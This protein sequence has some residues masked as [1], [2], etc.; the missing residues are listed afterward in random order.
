MLLMAAAMQ[1]KYTA[2]FEGAAMGLYLVWLSLR[3]RIGLARVAGRALLWVACALLPLAVVAASYAAL[4]SA[5]DFVRANFL[6]VLTTGPAT[7]PLPRLA[8]SLGLLAPLLLVALAGFV[9]SARREPIATW[10]NERLFVGLWAI[11]ALGGYLAFGTWLRHYALVLPGIAARRGGKAI[12]A[13]VLLTVAAVGTY[14]VIDERREHGS[15][16]QLAAL[17][18]V[19]APAVAYR[20][21]FLF[22]GPPALYAATD[23]CF[24]TRFAFPQ[25]LENTRFA[26]YPPGSQ[27]AEIRRIMAT[28]PGAVVMG[29]KP[30]S[31]TDPAARAVVSAA[32]TAGYRRAATLP[33]G[34]A[35]YDVWVREDAGSGR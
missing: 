6:S 28:R 13:L 19:V 20:C 4:G 21:L 32:L 33:V 15:I 17:T 5:E 26:A 27:V 12:A 1:V 2:V 3:A 10:P 8:T 30:L 14:R 24:A 31:Q 22:D 11:A 25:H 9:R 35:R 23:A 7:S 29:S 34:E 18:A 16:E